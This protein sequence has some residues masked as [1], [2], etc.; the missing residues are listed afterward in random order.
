MNEYKVTIVIEDDEEI[1]GDEF[2]VKA[3]S[4]DEAMENI[5]SKLDV[6]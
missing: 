5:K 1:Y 3:D 2:L 6:Y 4:I